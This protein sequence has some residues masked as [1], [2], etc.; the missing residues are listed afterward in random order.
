MDVTRFLGGL[1]ATSTKGASFLSNNVFKIFL[2]VLVVF[3]LY[4][5]IYSI[6][7]S[8]KEIKDENNN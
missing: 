8:R 6:I 7:K 5:V 1:S 4:L 2:G 3:I